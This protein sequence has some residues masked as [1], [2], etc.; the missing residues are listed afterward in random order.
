MRG[1]QAIGE[2]T[3]WAEGLHRGCG[4]S[5]GGGESVRGGVTRH[6]LMSQI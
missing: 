5:D 2:D 3:M 4:D 1:R 6:I